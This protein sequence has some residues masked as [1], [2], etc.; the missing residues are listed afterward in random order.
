[1]KETNFDSLYMAT[2]P[3]SG[4]TLIAQH[5]G[6]NNSIFH[7]GE[8]MYWEMLDPKNEVCS[9]GS[10]GCN[11]LQEIASSLTETHIARPLLKV[12]QIID[13]KYWP[14]KITYGDSVIQNNDNVPN[15]SE[16]SY[17]L[18]QSP[19]ALDFIVSVY[20]E[21]TPKKV[22]LDN[23]KLHH[24]AERLIQDKKN[25]GII[26]L[27]RDPRGMMSSFKNAGVR[28]GDFRKANSILPLC[29]EFGKF[30]LKY[31]QDKKIKIIKYEDFCKNPKEVL[32]K[33]C[34]FIGVDFEEK[35]LNPINSTQESR[36]HVLK[37]NHLLK[38]VK[39][40][41]IEEDKSWQKNLTQEELDSFYKNEELVNLYIKLGYNFNI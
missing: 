35:M 5:I 28:K 38:S 24:I 12:W 2:L 1:M 18:G 29:F 22:F 33:V 23:T 16:L 3:R 6:E 25:W 27:T 26:A 13:R 21:H 34:D 31:Q 17:W 20:R 8:S 41:S 36:G 40:I 15:D 30:I 39:L 19:Q 11:F 32:T 37:G 7:I 4:S 14:N 9:C 10:K